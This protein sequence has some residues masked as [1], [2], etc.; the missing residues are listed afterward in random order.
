MTD[1]EHTVSTLDT[2]EY[3]IEWDANGMSTATANIIVKL[4][5]NM[6]DEAGNRILLFDTMVAHRRCL[7][8]NTHTD[9]KFTDHNSKVQYK[10]STKGWQICVQWKDSSTS[11]EKLSVTKEYYS[12]K[13]DKHAVNNDIGGKPDFD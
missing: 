12:V 8:A 13:T 9:Q 10:R 1:R 2:C 11:W 7:T 6:C 3:K 4:M 5:Y